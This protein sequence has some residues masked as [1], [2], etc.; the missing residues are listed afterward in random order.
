MLFF[1]QINQITYFEMQSNIQSIGNLALR[2]FRVGEVD[3]AFPIFQEALEEN[4]KALSITST[5]REYFIPQSSGEHRLERV[6]RLMEDS[7]ILF[8][9]V[10]NDDDLFIYKQV[11]SYAIVFFEVV[12]EDSIEEWELR[13]IFNLAT[14]HYWKGFSERCSSHLRTAIRL[15]ELRDQ[16]TIIFGSHE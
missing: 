8:M 6:T 3:K 7:D 15:Y 13:C 9:D 10:Y 1:L 2:Y 5:G 14:F 16:S 12:S 11:N 4:R